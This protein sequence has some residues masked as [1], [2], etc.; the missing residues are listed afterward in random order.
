MKRVAESDGGSARK[1]LPKPSFDE[2]DD[3]RD[4]R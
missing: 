3:A 4:E 2:Q 1:V